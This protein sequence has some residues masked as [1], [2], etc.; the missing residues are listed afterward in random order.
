MELKAATPSPRGRAVNV[1]IKYEVQ[2]TV[3][4]DRV[5]HLIKL[6]EYGKGDQLTK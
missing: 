4:A 3:T 6:V 2:N 1:Y 5:S